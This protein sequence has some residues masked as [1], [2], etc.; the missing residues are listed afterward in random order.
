[1][2]I[3]RRL[4]ATSRMG[5]LERPATKPRFG[6]VIER[7][8]GITNTAFVHELLG[9][10]KL[11]RRARML[12]S[13]HHPSR[14][15]VWTLPLLHEALE[16]WL[17]EVYPSL[18]HG[19]L[20]ASPREVFE[21]DRFR[22]GERANAVRARRCGAPCPA[23]RNAGAVT[24]ATS[25]LSRGHHSRSSSVL[26]SRTSRVATSAVPLCWSRWIRSTAPSPTH[27]SVAAGWT[28]SLAD[29]DADLGGRSRKQISLAVKEL[30]TA[31]SCRRPG[32]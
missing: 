21:Q 32:A 16:K 15:A 25:I 17:F 7:L 24:R 29:G 28:C 19:S 13:S 10:T 9:N 22:S 18:R 20:G 8:F 5:K 12:S 2:S 30:R 14:D 4:S 23:G 6:A 26:A 11:L 3:S 1:M 27:G 31:A